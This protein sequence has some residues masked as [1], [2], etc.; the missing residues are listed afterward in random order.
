[1]VE[2]AISGLYAGYLRLIEWVAGLHPDNRGPEHPPALPFGKHSGAG[3][4]DDLDSR[5]IAASHT[6]RGAGIAI[7]LLGL[8]V[9]VMELV[10]NSMDA[11]SAWRAQLLFLKLFLMIAV[12]IVAIWAIRRDL[13]GEFIRLRAAAEELRFE[14]LELAARELARGS[15]SSSRRSEIDR[16]LRG[17]YNYQLSRARKYRA[18]TWASNRLTWLLFGFALAAAGFQ[19]VV[20]GFRLDFIRTAEYLASVAAIALAVLAAVQSINAFLRLEG[21]RHEARGIA[22]YLEKYV[23]GGEGEEPAGR[24]YSPEELAEL[25]KFLMFSET[26][27][28]AESLRSGSFKPGS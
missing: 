13:R 22:N 18:M 23:S 17:Q 15:L 16:L 8:G 20:L 24:E 9:V 5:A 3:G 7:A 4:Y 12:L 10:A 28:V 6:Y 19:C 21:Q 11:G 27:W 14:V 1:M 25:H 26:Q 2:R